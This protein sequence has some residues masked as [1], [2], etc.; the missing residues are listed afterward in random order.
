[1]DHKRIA[2]SLVRKFHTRDPMRIA[3]ALGHIIIRTPL[4]GIRG[5]WS[6]TQRRHL[7]FIDSS[8]SDHDAR[9][10]CAHELGHVLLHRGCNRI[11]LDSNTYFPTNRQEIEADRFAVDLLYDDEDLRF[12]TEY[13]IQLAADYM[14]TSTALAEYRLRSIYQYK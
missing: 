7:I 4:H 14:G 11:Y 3:Q 5:F 9:F 13:P 1:M 12:F 8:L 10:V 6:Y 2:E